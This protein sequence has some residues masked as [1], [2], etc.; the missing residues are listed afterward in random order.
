M[1]QRQRGGGFNLKL[2]L[3]T[4]VDCPVENSDTV[5]AILLIPLVN[6]V[7]SD[8]LPRIEFGCTVGA[9]SDADH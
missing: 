7:L 8:C 2:P 5:E 3:S 1:K 4:V 6:V 9:F